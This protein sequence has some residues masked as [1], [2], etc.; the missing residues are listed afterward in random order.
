SF[1]IRHKKAENEQEMRTKEP[2]DQKSIHGQ[3]RNVRMT[4]AGTYLISH[5]NL[6]RAIEYDKDW[7]E[8]RV[9]T[10]APWVGEATRLKNGNTMVSG[11]QHGFVREI[12]PKDEIVWEV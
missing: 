3:F 6:G 1:K 10:N 8:I 11:N 9:T 4:K 5:M 7:K 12:N 2:G